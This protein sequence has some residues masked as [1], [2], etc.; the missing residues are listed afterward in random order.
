MK[1]FES[2]I[3][4]ISNARKLEKTLIIPWN[5]FPEKIFFV[6]NLTDFRKT[7]ETGVDSHLDPARETSQFAVRGPLH[8]NSFSCNL[9][10]T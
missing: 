4:I 8:S 5:H 10:A 9:T 1:P 3:I 2:V 7:M 6:K